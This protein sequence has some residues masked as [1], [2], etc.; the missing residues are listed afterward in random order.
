[1]GAIYSQARKVLVW[2]GDE[3]Q[4]VSKVFA[5]FR[6]LAALEDGRDAATSRSSD[7]STDMIIPKAS[8]VDC[9]HITS[10]IFGSSPTKSVKDFFHRPWF[11]RRWVLQE[12]A[13]CKEGIICA[14]DPKKAWKWLVTGLQAL[15]ALQTNLEPFIVLDEDAHDA[16]DMALSLKNTPDDLL[17]SLWKFHASECSD[18]RDNLFS[19]AGFTKEK[20]ELAI[21]YSLPVE[22]AFTQYAASIISTCKDEDKLF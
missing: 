8:L 3:D 19:L 7:S 21:D 10:S 1:M 22:T 12:L 14:H 2:M 17:S 6:T 15:I 13:L 16:L 20:T 11:H 4:N 9:Q 18:P 5:F